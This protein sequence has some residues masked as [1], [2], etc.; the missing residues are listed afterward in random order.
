MRA[1]KAWRKGIEE[2]WEMIAGARARVQVGITDEKKGG[3]V[4]FE[5]WS[6][7][8]F[9]RQHLHSEGKVRRG[10]GDEEQEHGN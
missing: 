1:H 2:D 10:A 9:R 3:I 6:A 5:D 7:E 4:V 8:F